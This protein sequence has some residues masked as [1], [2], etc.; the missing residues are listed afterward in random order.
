[1]QSTGLDKLQETIIG[2]FNQM[3]FYGKVSGSKATQ[4]RGKDRF[5]SLRCRTNT[6]KAGFASMETLDAI[7]EVFCLLEQLTHARQ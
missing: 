1:M 4:H 7:R 2:S 5:D 3:D 6:Q